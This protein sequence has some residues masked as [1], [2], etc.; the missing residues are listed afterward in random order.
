M[1]NLKKLNNHILLQ[2]GAH[3]KFEIFMLKSTNILR[4]NQENQKK[5]KKTCI[6]SAKYRKIFQKHLAFLCTIV[7]NILSEIPSTKY[8]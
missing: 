1:K 5:E 7:Y 3:E 2:N 8:Y 4:E 6:F